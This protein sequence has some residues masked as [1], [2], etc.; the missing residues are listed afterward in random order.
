[1]NSMR[2]GDALNRTNILDGLINM[3]ITKKKDFI[4]DKLKKKIK[5]VD[6]KNELDIS[7]LSRI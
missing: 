2:N 7:K 1:M 5:N 4:K 3:W 6:K